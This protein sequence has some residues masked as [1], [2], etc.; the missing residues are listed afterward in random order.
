MKQL[1]LSLRAAHK[2]DIRTQFAALCY[3][4]KNEKVS[5]LLVTSRQTKRWILPKGWPME[6]KTPAESAAIEAW[7]E[8]GVT[9]KVHDQC[10]GIYSYHKDADQKTAVPCIGLIY[11][12]KVKKIA[13]QFPERRERRRKWLSP[14]KAAA[15][16]DSPELAALLRSFDPK[17]LKKQVS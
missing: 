15:R 3:R 4:I 6:G 14:K 10:A 8:A 9:G 11:P 5:I 2:S 7:E 13:T 12:L 17:R 16:V 1:P